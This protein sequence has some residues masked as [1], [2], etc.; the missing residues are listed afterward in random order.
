MT[1][2]L[3]R[4]HFPSICFLALCL[5]LL[6]GST[7]AVDTP[8][9]IGQLHVGDGKLMDAS[10][11]P[12]QLRGVS[13][14]GLIWF[15][16]FI[17]EELF[18]QLSEEWGV[19]L[20]RLAMYSDLYCGDEQE[21]SLALMKK[22]IDA[23][24]SS[25]LYVLV[26]WH[27]LEDSDPNQNADEAIDFFNQI[28]AEY[29]GIPNLLYEICNEPNGD[30]NWGDILEYSSRVIPVIRANSPEA[31]IIVG[32]PNFDQNLSGAVLRPIPFD[33]VMYTL[34][35]YAATHSEDLM[36]ELQA[37]VDAGIPVFI[38]ECGISESSG[39]GNLDFESAAIWFRYLNENR[40]SYAVWSFSN[41]NESSALLKPG[42]DPDRLITNEDLT[43]AGLWVR[44]VI[45]GTAPDE[46]PVPA[47]VIEKSWSEKLLSMIYGSAGEE[48]FDAVRIWWKFALGAAVLLMLAVILRR[49]RKSRTKE[50]IRTYDDLIYGTGRGNIP[51]D[52]A[53]ITLALSGFFTLIYLGWRICFSIPVEYGIPAVAANL[54]LLAVEILGF[55]ESL[56]MFDSLVGYCP[57]PLPK[58]Q[59]EAFPDVDV[60]IATYNE[61]AELLRRTVN[62]CKHM[63]YPDP[64]RVHIWLCDDNRRKEMRL[65]AEE[66][67]I[68]YFDRPDNKGAKAGNLNHAMSLTKAPYIV[69]LDADMIPKSDF[70][71]KTIPY[72]VYAELKDPEHKLG[73]LQTPQCFYQPD[74]FQFGLYSEKRAPNEQ[75]FFYRTIEPAKTSTNSVIYGGSN[76]VL[77]RKALEDIGGFYTESITEDF[78]TGLLIEAAGYLSLA[79]SEP[80]ASG[81]TPHTYREHIRQRT[82]WGRGVIATARKLKIWQRKDLT[83]EQKISYWS[84]VI[85][86]YSPLKNLI[87]VLAPLLFG[88][89]ALPVFKCSWPDLLIFWLPMYLIQDINLLT[90]SRKTISQKWA[91]I[92][93]TSVMPSLLIP[94]LKE[95]FGLSLSEFKVTKKSGM[96]EKRETDRRSMIP[97]LIL[98]VLSSAGLL[99]V[100]STFERAQTI[101]LF[102]LLF[103]LV[104]SLY[105]ELLALF[106]IDGRDSDTEPV[107]VV[108]AIPIR[109]ETDKGEVFSGVTTRMTEHNLSVYLDEGDKLGIGAHVSIFIRTDKH[110]AEMKGMVT[111]VKETR[112]SL[113]RTQKIDIY[114]FGTDRYEYWEILYDRIPTLP[115]SYQRDFGIIS[116][117]WQNIAHRIARTIK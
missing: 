104:R 100:L 3:L 2:K 18:Q 60:F 82:R 25:G 89:F 45:R 13:T 67:G 49:F 31:I 84:S 86:W 65:L 76:T 7:L 85:Y 16:D 117:L 95:S 56:V 88:V 24:I 91:G 30:T 14:H 73:L 109:V 33:N 105:F 47:A 71:L 1:R 46:I 55:L 4:K 41:K 101:S 81:Q 37:S 97:F 103:W 39:D 98:A 77:S 79:L 15:P 106:L 78:A 17:S 62:G 19:N 64:S 35:F 10:G 6:T 87:Y 68:G 75:D 96:S 22:G 74:V 59:D 72:F 44:E 70:L 99:R 29:A 38:T 42:F 108:D 28:S 48:G 107:V 116:H 51:N 52:R 63:S 53:R 112:S 32:T 20:V 8:E 12:V 94:I 27:I 26:D 92:Y 54:I 80:L 110:K 23:A 34:H 5:V 69:T 113:S 40:V 58:I 61:P 90:V 11:Q 93:E 21:E 57:H 83:W 43:P 66:M 114:D 102:I 9:I 115:Q 50:Q 111:E 36:G